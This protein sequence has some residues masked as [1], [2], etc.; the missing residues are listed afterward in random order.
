MPTSAE[1]RLIG[2]LSPALHEA[3]EQ[4]RPVRVEH[5]HTIRPQREVIQLAARLCLREQAKLAVLPADRG[6]VF[7]PV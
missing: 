1:R 4:G 5:L 2:R 3:V 7:V 6:V